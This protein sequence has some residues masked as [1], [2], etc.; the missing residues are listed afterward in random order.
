MSAKPVYDARTLLSSAF[1]L[2]YSKL[3]VLKLNRITKKLE[4]LAVYNTELAKEK[5]CVKNGIIGR[6]SNSN[7]CRPVEVVWMFCKGT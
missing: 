4:K 1:N 6:C 3:V 5:Y 7:R 2:G